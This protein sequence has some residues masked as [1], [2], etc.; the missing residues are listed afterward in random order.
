MGKV[1]VNKADMK[2]VEETNERFSLLLE[3]QMNNCSKK[4]MDRNET[5]KTFKTF[6]KQLKNIFDIILSQLEENEGSDAMFA[7][8]PLGGWSCVSCQK[9][10]TTLAGSLAEYQITGKFP[11]RDPTDRLNHV[12]AGFSK[13]LQHM[14]PESLY[15]NDGMHLTTS[16]S[17]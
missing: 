7:K 9:K 8:K 11:F 6:E 14:R 17:Q 10:L 16:M 12:G 4:F 5:K 3:K 13:M 15:V 2:Q 1:I